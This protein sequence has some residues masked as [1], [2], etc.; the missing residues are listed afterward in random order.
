MKIELASSGEEVN[1]K[2]RSSDNYVALI[3]F[4][5]YYDAEKKKLNVTRHNVPLTELE[6][7]LGFFS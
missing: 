6:D 2:L 7:Q 5:E 1:K 3:D 4:T